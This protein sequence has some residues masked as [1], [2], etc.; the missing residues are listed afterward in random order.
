MSTNLPVE[1]KQALK[2]HV[3]AIAKILFEATDKEQLK[4]TRQNVFALLA[5]DGWSWRLSKLTGAPRFLGLSGRLK[6]FPISSPYA[7]LISIILSHKIMGCSLPQ[8][9]LC[10]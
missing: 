4:I 1:Q 2:E 10:S 8:L 9:F 6:I 5:L 7:P 3:R